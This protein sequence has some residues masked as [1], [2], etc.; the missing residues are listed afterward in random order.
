MSDIAARLPGGDARLHDS[1]P[2]RWRILALVAVGMLLSMSA[3]MTATAVGADLQA[4]WDLTTGQVGMLTTTVQLGFV[5]GTAF[6]A[7]LNLGDIVP[8]RA[9]FAASAVLAAATNASLL[10]APGYAYALGAR[11]LTGVFMAGVYPPGMKMVST[12]FRSGR[13]LAI[14]TTVGALTVGKA[15]PYLLKAMGGPGL[16][17]VIGGA[18]AAGLIAAGLVY[19]GYREGP[20]AFPKRPFAWSR[21]GGI[22]THRE[23]MLA[24]GGYLGHMWELYAMWTWVPTFLAVAAADRVRPAIVDLVA[25]GTIAAGA[26]GCVWGGQVADRIGRDRVVNTAMVVSGACCIL[27]GLALDGPFWIVAALSWLWGLAVVA[28]SAQFS[29][30]VTEVAPADSV[31]TALMLQTS[32]GFLLTM[33]TI[34]AVP[35]TVDLVGWRWA[36]AFLALGPMAGITSIRRLVRVQRID[37]SARD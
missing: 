7:I 20:F 31:G 30:V 16:V 2:G 6:A 11:L 25:F 15:L 36:F 35:V 3:W 8:A 14:G 29:A 34:Q 32:L 33:V 1:D 10:V 23:T 12:W 18:S 4:R 19:G 27:A 21:I 24:T 26:V 9:L 28:D 13:G 17:P 5:V 37:S 22:L